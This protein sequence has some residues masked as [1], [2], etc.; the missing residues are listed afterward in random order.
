MRISEG[1]KL[2]SVVVSVFLL[3]NACKGE[4]VDGEAQPNPVRDRA[5]K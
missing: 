3:V 1:G 2:F 4:E 5:I